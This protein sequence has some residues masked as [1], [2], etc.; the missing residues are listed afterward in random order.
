M[1]IDVPNVSAAVTRLRESFSGDVVV[2]GDEGYDDARRVWNALFDRRPALIVRPDS[3]AAVVE[4]VRFARDNELVVSVRCGGHSVTGFST[5]D[6]GIVIDLSAMRGAHVD[7][8]QRRASV[9]G[10]ALLGELDEAAQ[11]FGL[12]CPVG[13][14]SHTGVGGL[15]LGGGMGRIM[16]KHGLTIDNLVAAEMVSADGR[17]VTASA[18]ENPELFWGLR[19]A[20]A[21]FGI[22][23]RFEF[24]LHPIGETVTQGFALYPFERTREVVDLFREFTATAPDEV[25]VSL[26]LGPTMP[27]DPPELGSHVVGI[28]ATHCGSPAA[29]ER[30][31]AEIRSFGPPVM[32]TFDVKRYL[33]VQ[34]AGDDANAWGNRFYM[35]SGF[36][37]DLPPGFTDAATAR[38]ADSPGDCSISVWSWGRAIAATEDDATAFNGRGASFWGGAEVMWRDPSAD[39]AHRAWGRETMAD[40]QPFTIAGRYVND[41]VE[42]G[43][44]VV[45]LVYGEEKYAR[46]VALKRAWDP[47]NVFR[48]N[49][50]VRP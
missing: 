42:T 37:A 23:T 39:D 40:L 11:A 48:L 8:E 5:C 21:N 9:G 13:V 14:V 18:E 24:R 36:F 29:A 33:D 12:A 30:D 31:L 43:T 17:V 47:D 10:G 28:G 26:M 15:T 6:G 22:V 38:V 19:G 3:V 20:G 35:K 1:A 16:R 50:N 32:D 27:G 25:T 7:P 4:A 34:R 49:Q 2:P 41:V 44:D 45:R 46:L